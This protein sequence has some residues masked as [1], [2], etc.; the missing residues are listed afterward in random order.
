MKKTDPSSGPVKET[1]RKIDK[2]GSVVI[3]EEMTTDRKCG[4]YDHYL[5][6]LG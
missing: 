5:D 1:N 3:R 4:K 6:I 2:T